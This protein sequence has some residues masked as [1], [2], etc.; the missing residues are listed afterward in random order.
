MQGDLVK[1]Q[2]DQ[3]SS[4]YVSSSTPPPSNLSLRGSVNFDR[5]FTEKRQY[6]LVTNR[7][8]VNTSTKYTDILFPSKPTTT[9]PQPQITY[10]AGSNG[11]SQISVVR[12]LQNGNGQDSFLLCCVE[13]PSDALRCENSVRSSRECSRADQSSLAQNQLS[14]SSCSSNKSHQLYRSPKES[15]HSNCSSNE[16]DQSFRGTNPKNQ[17]FS[18]SESNVNHFKAKYNRYC[19]PKADNTV[20]SSTDSSATVNRL[21]C[22]TNVIGCSLS[23]DM[24]QSP[25]GHIFKLTCNSYL[26]NENGLPPISTDDPITANNHLDT[27]DHM[28][29]NFDD[30]EVYTSLPRDLWYLE[31]SELLAMPD[32]DFAKYLDDK[33]HDLLAPQIE[34]SAGEDGVVPS[35]PIR[36]L[37]NP[38]TPDIS[39]V[40]SQELELFDCCDESMYK[41]PLPVITDSPQYGTLNWGLK[42]TIIYKTPDGSTFL[43]DDC[44]NFKKY[45]ISAGNVQILTPSPSSDDKSRRMS[46]RMKDKRPRNKQRVYRKRDERVEDVHEVPANES[47]DNK[48]IGKVFDSN[49]DPMWFEYEKEKSLLC[50]QEFSFP[51]GQNSESGASDNHKNYETYLDLTNVVN[52]ISQEPLEEPSGTLSSTVDLGVSCEGMPRLRDLEVIQPE[53]NLSVRKR[54]RSRTYSKTTKAS[55][56][57]RKNTQPK[58]KNDFQDSYN[59]RS[60]NV[61]I[62]NIDGYSPSNNQCVTPLLPSCLFSV[63]W[64]TMDDVLYNNDNLS[65]VSDGFSHGCPQMVPTLQTTQTSSQ[66][67]ERLASQPME[68]N[69]K[70]RSDWFHQLGDLV[71]MEML[72]G[73]AERSDVEINSFEKNATPNGLMSFFTEK[74]NSVL[75][76]NPNLQSKPYEI[77]KRLIEMWKN[78]SRRERTHFAQKETQ[79]KRN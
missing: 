70:P 50:E 36:L 62:E 67:F 6:F 48:N 59:D 16:S 37:S 19:S 34:R 55:K 10:A 75:I 52:S 21:D 38:C 66:T 14:Q 41:S 25:S 61:P 49:E 45:S 15:G 28:Q 5:Q 69:T 9:L 4:D 51:H 44:N 32:G 71:Q 60:K 1:N 64:S 47:T 22:S 46:C 27:M 24:V 23:T 42:P 13:R 8:C 20:A 33:D 79:L 63:P 39:V 12:F 76:D 73:R 68:G 18:T 72:P 29:D 26:N 17:S 31:K 30:D 74:R 56:S 3:T 2:L 11:E 77:T 7:H 40:D 43:E 78:L 58:K 54:K 57:R 35:S 65:S 53:K